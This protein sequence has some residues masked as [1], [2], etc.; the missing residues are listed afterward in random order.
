MKVKVNTSD[1]DCWNE[2]EIVCPF[3]GGVQSDSYEYGEGEDIGKVECGYCGREFFA[4]R[5]ISITYSS[6]PCGLE[7][8][9]DWEEGDVFD[10]GIDDLEEEEWCNAAGVNPCE[11]I[12]EE[13]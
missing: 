2:D 5:L 3:C 12:K 9:E 1:S 13:V 10:D 7:S 8:Y 11:V 4:E 6:R